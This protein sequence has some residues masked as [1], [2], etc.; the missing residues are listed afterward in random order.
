[1][2]AILQEIYKS[3]EFAEERIT[4]CHGRH[5]GLVAEGQEELTRQRKRKSYSTQRGVKNL[6]SSTDSWN[7]AGSLSSGV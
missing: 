5:G 7:V 1:M 3:C 2:N 6:S 4:M